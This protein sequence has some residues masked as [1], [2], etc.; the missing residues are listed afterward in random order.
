MKVY[1]QLLEFKDGSHITEVKHSD[2][3]MVLSVGDQNGN[4]VAWFLTNTN[5]A[6]TTPTTIEV[7][8][9]GE[10]PCKKD[11]KFL[12]TVLFHN[13]IYVL[14]FFILDPKEPIN[15]VTTVT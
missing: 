13:G 15:D 9:T 14:H 4:A 8:P 11:S 7:V 6:Q 12:G 5:R 10:G 2:D 1:K 3:G